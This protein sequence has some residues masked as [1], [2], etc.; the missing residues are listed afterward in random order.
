M[1]ILQAVNIFG[2]PLGDD[3][4]G[5]MLFLFIIQAALIL[6]TF[7][8]LI[9]VFVVLMRRRGKKQRNLVGLEI[10]A[11][12]AQRTYAPGEAFDPSGLIVTAV[13]SEAPFRERVTDF[14]VKAPRTDT[15]GK[16]VA[17]VTYRDQ[18]GAYGIEVMSSPVRQIGKDIV[19]LP[20]NVFLISGPGYNGNVMLPAQSGAAVYPPQSLVREA[21][22]QT[23]APEKS[24][25]G[26]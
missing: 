21:P 18:T 14:T 20:G 13:Y 25:E 8:A 15:V 2:I 11:G 19:R 3:A 1:N 7:L 10:D 5:A 26:D 23:I 4:D 12:G 22:V 24:G 16:K 17:E 6:V 9:V